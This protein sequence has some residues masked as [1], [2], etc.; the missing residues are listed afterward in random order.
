MKVS[1]LESHQD[2]QSLER[3]V[4]GLLTTTCLTVACGS[5][6]IASSVFEGSGPPVPADFPNFA[7]GYLLPV[8]TTGVTG[9]IGEG[10]GAE[11]GFDSSDWFEFQ[12]LTGSASY[13]LTGAPVGESSIRVDLFDDSA[14]PGSPIGSELDFEGALGIPHSVT[15]TSP[16]DGNVV[17]DVFTA[18]DCDGGPYTLTLSPDSIPEP[19][20]LA[21]VGLGLTGIAVAWR[22]RRSR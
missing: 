6:A 7:N 11:G 10:A 14:T 21:G 22:R 16:G 15:F 2:P 18:C 4:R 9:T 17:V 5:S 13:T 3:F 20:T 12:G 8:G 19:S 1:E